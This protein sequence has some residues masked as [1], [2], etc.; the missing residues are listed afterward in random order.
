MTLGRMLVTGHVAVLAAGACLA[1]DTVTLSSGGRTILEY[2]QTQNPNKVYVA[3]L[4]SPAGVQVLLD[5]PPDHVHHHGLMY[6]L[7]TDKTGFWM[8]GPQQGV[9]KP[10]GPAGGAATGRVE[11]AINWV[12]PG[13]QTVLEE[14]RRIAVADAGPSPATLL[15]W[16]SR[17]A[18]PGGNPPVP[19]TTT[20]SYVG[21]G[22]RFP[23]SMDRAA[24]FLFAD[25][26]DVA[27]VRNTEK[28][29]R[30]RWCACVGPVDGKT[31]TAAMFSHPGNYRHPA[32]WFTMSD[33]LTYMTATLNLYRQ[34]LTLV[35]GKPLELTYGIAV[36]DGEAKMEEIESLY[37]RWQA[38][39]PAP[40]KMEGDR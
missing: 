17:L 39:T 13:G 26:K 34:P 31:V 16:T 12:T 29:T 3:K 1:A 27:P 28:V 38:A 18:V 24:K 2:R 20:R 4:Y 19:L 37:Q 23:K 40:E 30:D 7:D 33:S 25:P 5:S 32:S 6:A 9:Q 14:Q 21:L 36:W 35:A 8:D 10:A 22:F 15:T 11:Q